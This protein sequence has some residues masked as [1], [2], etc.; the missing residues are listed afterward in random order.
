MLMIRLENSDTV[1]VPRYQER[2][3]KPRKAVTFTGK[4]ETLKGF[5]TI[6]NKVLDRKSWLSFALCLR[7]VQV[8]NHH[9]GLFVGVQLIT[10]NIIS[11]PHPPKK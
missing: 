3:Y 7:I 11:R 1:F 5:V 4:A 6:R 10:P 9:V 8:K 2:Q